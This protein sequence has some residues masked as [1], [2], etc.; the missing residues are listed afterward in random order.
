MN[1][2]L[3]THIWL[4]SVLDSARLSRKVASALVNPDNQ[5]WLSPVSIWEVLI[6]GEKRRITLNKET[7]Q[8]IRWALE[9]IPL[10]QAP[11]NHEVAL[12]ISEV[13]LPS[14]DPADRFLA[15]TARVHDLKLVTTDK[16]LIAGKGFAVLPNR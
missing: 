4:W 16:R 3:D 14:N 7:P 15:A 10:R 9:R 2:L 5:L 6:L 13:S 1:L 11:L 12:A 8:W